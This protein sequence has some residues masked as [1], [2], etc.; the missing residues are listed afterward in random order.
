MPRYWALRTDQAR[1]AFIWRELQAGRLRQGWGY[2]PELDLEN[3]AQLRHRG[4]KLAKYQQDAW[5]GNRRLLPSEPGSMQTGDIVVLLHLPGYGSWS[6]ARVTGGYRFEISD[7]PNDV[8]GTPD[9]GH[10]RPVE[11]LTGDPIDPRSDI[12]SDDLRRAMR[13]RIRM[14]SLD[15]HGE[16]IDRLIRGR[17]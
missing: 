16:E 9:Y 14:W 10:I 8:D 13:P 6:I 12:V 5:R 1:R 7:E 2:R 17:P 4:V 11:L 3:L 15:G